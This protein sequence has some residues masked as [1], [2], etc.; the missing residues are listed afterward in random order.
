MLEKRRIILIYKPYGK[1]AE[2]HAFHSNKPTR[3]QQHFKDDCSID[4]ILK[5]FRISGVLGDP[6]RLQFMQYLDTT[7]IPSIQDAKDILNQLDSDFATLP[8]NIRALFSNN[9]LN[10]ANFIQNP[11]NSEECRKLGLL[12]PLPQTAQTAL[13]AGEQS[14]LDV[15]VPTDTAQS[16]SVLTPSKEEEK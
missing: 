9:S 12:P 5:Q 2:R 7:E 13:S 4:R 1:R 16:G 15:T 11:E 10:L 6:D 3:T 14:I 8:A